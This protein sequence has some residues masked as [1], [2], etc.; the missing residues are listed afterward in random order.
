M[1]EH[2]CSQMFTVAQ[3][4]VKNKNKKQKQKQ[5]QKDCKDNYRISTMRNTIQKIFK[6]CHCMNK[7]LQNDMKNMIY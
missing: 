1:C 5:Q 3:F 2:A 7:K 6:T 4:I